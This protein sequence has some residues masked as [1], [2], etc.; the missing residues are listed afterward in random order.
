MNELTIDERAFLNIALL[1]GIRFLRGSVYFLTAWALTSINT[2]SLTHGFLLSVVIGA[3]GIGAVTARL[4][5]VA[6]ACLLA[7]AVF[8][9]PLVESLV[10][11]RGV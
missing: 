1:W 3:L 6:V 2:Y 4:S 11:A 8:P 9:L 7:M 10:S 5:L